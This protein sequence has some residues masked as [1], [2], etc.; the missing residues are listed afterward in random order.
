[1]ELF[2]TY[3]QSLPQATNK[4]DKSH[5]ASPYAASATTIANALKDKY[6][7]PRITRHTVRHQIDKRKKWLSDNGMDAVSSYSTSKSKSPEVE[8]CSSPPS[9]SSVGSIATSESP[10]LVE[11]TPVRKKTPMTRSRTRT[12]QMKSVNSPSRTPSASNSVSPTLN[13]ENPTPPPISMKPNCL[14]AATSYPPQQPQTI[15]QPQNPNPGY[16]YQVM[17]QQPPPQNQYY[18]NPYAMGQPLK[19]NPYII[20]TGYSPAAMSQIQA[21]VTNPPGPSA[22]GLPIQ[23]PPPPVPAY[24]DSGCNDETNDLE[25]YYRTFL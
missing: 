14:P 2:D 10:K 19:P 17:Y 20:P 15:Y 5:V 8:S 12:K 18:V 23:P 7:D 4:M 16:P 21:Y 1:M 9:V 22:Y 6:K 3:I 13:K 24:V 11:T 25:S